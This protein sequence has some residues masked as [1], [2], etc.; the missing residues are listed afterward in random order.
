MKNRFWL[1]TVFAVLS[2]MLLATSSVYAADQSSPVLKNI[3]KTN[4]L[5]VG[6]SGAQ[7]P[8]N[9][10]NRDGKIIGMDVDLAQLLANSMG[11]DLKIVDMP[12]A[13][14]LPALEDGDVDIVMSGVTA[15]LERNTRVPF[16][17]PYFISGI[18]ILTKAETIESIDSEEELNKGNWRIAALKGSTSETFAE[19]VLKEP[20]MTAT[21]THAEAVQLLL[22][23]KVDA[24]VADAPVC[25][26]SVL[27][28]PDSGLVTLNQPLT[29]EPIGI[30]LAPGDPL[31]VNLVQNYMQ[32]LSATGA[33][34]ALQVKW[35]NNAAWMAQM[36]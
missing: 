27:R 8:F 4:T 16:V 23:G 2:T 20:Q 17:G 28:N 10:T 5:R 6:M 11:V 19:S 3:A 31:L 32:A 24:V 21:D 12:F 36:P 1:G 22:D 18:S 9:M 35:F 26:L 15:T 25:A 34:E 29:L 7:A 13:K 14:L 30:A 33:L